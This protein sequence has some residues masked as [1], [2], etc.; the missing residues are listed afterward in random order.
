MCESHVS[1]NQLLAIIFVN[2]HLT[3]AHVKPAGTT[4]LAVTY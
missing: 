4:G 2:A 1:G 3:P